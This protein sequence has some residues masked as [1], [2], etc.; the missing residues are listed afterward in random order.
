MNY[1]TSTVNAFKIMILC[2][3]NSS[4][5]LG[6]IKDE[7]RDKVFKT[8]LYDYEYGMQCAPDEISKKLSEYKIELC[9][10]LCSLLGLNI[11]LNSTTSENLTL[12]IQNTLLAAADAVQSEVLQNKSEVRKAFYTLVYF[13]DMLKD[14]DFVTRNTAVP[15]YA[16]TLD[17]YTPKFGNDNVRNLNFRKDDKPI[18]MDEITSN[19]AKEVMNYLPLVNKDGTVS[20]TMKVGWNGFQRS[21]TTFMEWAKENLDKDLLNRITDGDIQA[22]ATGIQTYLRD[23]QKFAGSAYNTLIN[24]EILRSLLMFVFPTSGYTNMPEQLQ[25]LFFNQLL[26]TAKHAYLGY[27]YDP[28]DKSINLNLIEDKAI[29]SESSR[30]TN[31]IIGRITDLLQNPELY[32]KLFDKQHGK[33]QNLVVQDT[34]AKDTYSISFSYFADSGI[35]YDFEFLASKVAQGNDST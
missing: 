12:S 31:I 23:E 14:L 10:T 22:L 17:M 30:L 16:H 11:D 2:Y 24:T 34:F 26:K 5:V 7:F 13:D 25:N 32:N 27:D 28:R 4:F 21:V 1:N 3:I 35:A 33:I 20:K 29:R 15:T 6:N 9:Q 8:C 19:L 18:D